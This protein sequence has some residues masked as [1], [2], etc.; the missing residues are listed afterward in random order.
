MSCCVCAI[1]CKHIKIICCFQDFRH[2]RKPPANLIRASK[3]SLAGRSQDSLHNVAE[4][5]HFSEGT[6][7]KHASNECLADGSNVLDSEDDRDDDDDESDESKCGD[8][9]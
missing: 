2:V 8:D 1:L 5:R 4:N 7:K 3:G 6:S 9:R